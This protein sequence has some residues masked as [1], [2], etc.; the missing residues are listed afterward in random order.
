MSLFSRAIASKFLKGSGI[1]S[2]AD[3]ATRII[4]F[5]K[6][7]AV[8]HSFL[9]HFDLDESSDHKTRIISCLDSASAISFDQSF[10]ILDLSRHSSK[11][12]YANILEW[13][14]QFLRL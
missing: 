11:P 3:I 8:I 5:P 9:T 10:S 2:K 6:A 7:L 13:F 14:Q 1:F 12:L 4:G